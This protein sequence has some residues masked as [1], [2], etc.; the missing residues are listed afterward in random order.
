MGA[1]GRRQR[2][3][4]ASIAIAAA[5]GVLLVVAIAAIS[6]SR[7]ELLSEG[8]PAVASSI[9]S[10]NMRAA[11]AVDGDRNTRWASQ[12]GPDPQWLR[13][14]LGAVTTIRRAILYWHDAYPTA[15]QL[16]TSTD[17]TTWSVLYSTPR[18]DGGTDDLTHLSGRGRYLRVFGTT[19][20]TEHAMSLSELR[21]YGRHQPGPTPTSGCAPPLPRDSVPPSTRAP[22]YPSNSPPPT[23]PVP[24]EHPI[25]WTQRWVAAAAP[26]TDSRGERWAPDAAVA[27]GGSLRTSTAAIPDTG[28]PALY[29]HQRTGAD[30]Y[31]LP[32]PAAGTWVVVLYLAGSDGATASFDIS[33]SGDAGGQ[34][35]AGHVGE[36]DAPRHV[37]LLAMASGPGTIT[38]RLASATGNLAVSA[39]ALSLA[40]KGSDAL[41]VAYGD[42]FSGSVGAPVDSGWLPETGNGCPWGGSELQAYTDRTVNAQLDGAGRLAISAQQEQYTEP[43]WTRVQQYTS[44]RLTSAY[45]GRY[46]HIEASLRVPPGPGVLPAFWL[47]GTDIATVNWPACGEIDVMEALGDA[48]PGTVEAHLH[49]P[50][51]SPRGWELGGT[52]QLDRALSDGFHT[53]AVDWWPGIIQISVDGDVYVSVTPADLRQGRTWVFD[54]PF[55]LLLNV[56]VGGEWAGEPPANVTWPQTMLVDHVR[57]YS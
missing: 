5:A 24:G 38:V 23:A 1:T 15:Y 56:A 40:R 46:G 54:K 47:M 26:V 12:P 2:F 49:G 8:R 18:G 36:P 3:V 25:G 37:A 35:R 30:R 39:V 53:Y 55:Y 21:V 16:Q 20:A 4:W 57:W 33:V 6:T 14:D 44:A 51:G 45:Q 34:R 22:A 31:E 19:T 32:A 7:E 29:Q 43:D 50:D 13:V 17:A 27:Q 9:A 42:D 52:R 11:R 48:D 10:A 41:S 28:S